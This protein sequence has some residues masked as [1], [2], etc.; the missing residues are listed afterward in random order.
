MLGLTTFSNGNSAPA[1]VQP[2]RYGIVVVGADHARGMLHEGRHGAGHGVRFVGNAELAD[3]VDLVAEYHGLRASSELQHMGHTLFLG[4][5]G[6]ANRQ[7]TMS[8]YLV[9]VQGVSAP[10]PIRRNAT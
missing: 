4:S 7:D 2:A 10:R 9:T 8:V 6:V 1:G 5:A 3:I